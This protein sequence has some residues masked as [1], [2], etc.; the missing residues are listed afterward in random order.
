MNIIFI[1]L[2]VIFIFCL[3]RYETFIDLSLQ[4]KNEL[5]KKVWILWLQGWE[6]APWLSKRVGE[7]WEINNPEWEVIYLSL[8][9]LKDYV[10]DIDYIYD[11]NKNISQAAKSDIIR[12]SIL[13]NHG[14]VWAD[15]TMLCLQPLDHW[16]FDAVKPASLW[17][18]H[19]NGGSMINEEGPASWFIIAIDNS[20]MITKWKESCDNYW[21]NNNE[22]H[23][24]FWMDILF[25]QLFES[26]DE[27]KKLWLKVPHIYCEL[28]DQSNVTGHHIMNE[29]S[30]EFKEFILNKP[31]YAIK[32][33]NKLWKEIFPEPESN[34][35]DNSNGYY[36]IKMSTRQFIYKHEMK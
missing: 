26:D 24:Y 13:K 33:C 7:S 19:G 2:F 31:P 11:E 21:N 35:Y 12:L 36:A 3:F 8:E 16:I 1:I 9:N 27:F 4:N 6:H 28:R 34:K 22:A 25:R 29:D 32:L 30:E 14:G 18:Y 20:Y 15:A 17:M 23:D 5:N 10:N